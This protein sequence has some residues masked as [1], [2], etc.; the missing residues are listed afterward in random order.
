MSMTRGTLVTG[1]FV[2][3]FAVGVLPAAAQ[4]GKAGTA[5]REIPEGASRVGSAVSRGGSDPAPPSSVGDTANAGTMSSP[6]GAGIPPSPFSSPREY[7]VAPVH[8]AERQQTRQRGEGG[9]R[10]PS[11]GG[12]SSGRAVPRGSSE[13]GRPG[14]T[15]SGTSATA[16]RDDSS[17]PTRRAVPEYSRPRDGRPVLGTAV[18]RR[19]PRVDPD[20][21]PYYYYR[22]PY[23][24]YYSPARRYYS[25][26]YGFGLGFLYDPLWYDPFFYGGYD[27]YGYGYG[28]GYGGYYG[29][30][31]SSGYARGETG[32]LRLK[33]KPREAEVHVDGFFVG[34]VD[35]FDGM[36]QKLGIDAGT[37]RIEIRAEGYEPIQLDVLLTPG[38]TVTYKGELKRR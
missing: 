34:T 32:S 31:G 27:P 16:G 6:A 26:A 12:S 33:I 36:F 13:G 29:G 25:P 4:N 8:P 22:S 21:Y 2:A 28:G 19:I 24:G 17:A 11:G 10:Q 9:T 35:N 23:F 38:E 15:S 30:T 37:H 20:D 14:G 3:V 1:A 5:E 18:D 7:V